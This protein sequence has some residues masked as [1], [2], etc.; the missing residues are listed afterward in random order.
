MEISLLSDVGFVSIFAYF[1]GWLLNLFIFFFV[2][3][4]PFSLILSHLFFFGFVD[5]LTL[6]TFYF[7]VGKLRPGEE[8]G[9]RWGERK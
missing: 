3:Q 5:G 2:I 1:I 6:I 4:K 8:E 7:Q 9:D